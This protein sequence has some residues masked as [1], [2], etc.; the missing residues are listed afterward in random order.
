MAFHWKSKMYKTLRN[1]V[2]ALIKDAKKKKIIAKLEKI[3]LPN[4]SIKH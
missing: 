3:P 1:K 2:S 4:V